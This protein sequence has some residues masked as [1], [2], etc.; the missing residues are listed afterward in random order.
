M[1]LKSP[2]LLTVTYVDLLEDVA[3]ELL[4]DSGSELNLIKKSVLAEGVKLNTSQRVAL[5]GLSDGL[6]LT[7]GTIVIKML[8][9]F[10]VKFHV[11]LDTLEFPYDGIF[12]SDFHI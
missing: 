1:N 9:T 2:K 12:G 11:I 6:Y 10:E 4:L 7:M 3:L 5:K 8:G